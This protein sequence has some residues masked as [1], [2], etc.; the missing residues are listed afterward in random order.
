MTVLLR[1]C[2]LLLLLL[3]AAPLQAR[4]AQPPLLFG[5]LPYLST[6]TLVAT[7]APLAAALEKSL[8]RPVQLQTAPDFDTFTRRAFAGEYD[9]LLIAPHYGRLAEVDYGYIPLVRHKN[10]IRCLLVV[11][12]DAPLKSLDELRGQTVAIH[13]RSAMVPLLGLHWL[14]EKGLAVDRD[15]RA[16]E[17]VTQTSALQSMVSGKARAAIISYSTL[18]QAPPELQ[19][20]TRVFEECPSAPGLVLMAHN[21]LAK[22]LRAAVRSAL[23]AFE[24]TPAGQDFFTVST[25][26]GYRDPTPADARLMDKV[27]PETRLLLGQ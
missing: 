20:A 24:R 7:Y 12:Q 11:A 3:L 2:T 13:E 4:E 1:R 8:G 16:V 15:F 19:Q 27:L 17:N 23:Y 10:D 22:P 25:H 5:V 6:R 18:F 21:R 9:L 14:G 26:G